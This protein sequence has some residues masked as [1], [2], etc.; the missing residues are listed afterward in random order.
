MENNKKYSFSEVEKKDVFKEDKL[1]ESN[2][3][4]RFLWLILLIL[5]FGVFY[6]FIPLSIYNK[7][8]LLISVLGSSVFTFLLF[9]LI[10]NFNNLSSQNI[11][12][13]RTSIIFLFVIIWMFMTFLFWMHFSASESTEIRNNGIK[14]V[15]TILD[16]KSLKGRRSTAYSIVVK[17]NTVENVEIIVNESVGEEEFSKFKIGQKVELVYSKNDPKIIELLTNKSAIKNYYS[18]EERDLTISDLFIL[19]DLVDSTRLKMLKKI[20]YEWKLNSD[21]THYIKGKTAAISIA[22]S[23]KL[24]FYS[25][26]SEYWDFQEELET[27]GFKKTHDSDNIKTYESSTLIVNIQLVIKEL[28]AHTITEIYKTNLN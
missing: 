8:P 4:K 22:E 18:S 3:K 11:N 19:I 6:S 9:Q 20:A 27:L 17:F 25:M 21:S 5:T 16:G 2:S 12:K 28:Q 23:E 24:I 7:S 13:L 10:Y 14:A 1:K 26:G 15:G